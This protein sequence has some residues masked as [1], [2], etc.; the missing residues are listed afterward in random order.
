MPECMCVLNLIRPPL[1]V[2]PEGRVPAVVVAVAEAEEIPPEPVPDRAVPREPVGHLAVAMIP[3]RVALRVP[4]TVVV[5]AREA[6]RVLPEVQVPET[7]IPGPAVVDRVLPA[8]QA[9]EVMIPGPEALATAVRQDRE[10]VVVLARAALRV[11]EP[12]VIPDR[13]VPRVQ[14]A[15]L[16]VAVPRVRAGAQPR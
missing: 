2:V 13:E 1:V 11:Q 14:A 9:L 6:L 10:A 3:D 12:A 15:R 4:A 8:V 16:A 7:A 5:L